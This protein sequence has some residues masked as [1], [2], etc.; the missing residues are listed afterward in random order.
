MDY[1]EYFREF[2]RLGL[3]LGL[4]EQ[5]IGFFWALLEKI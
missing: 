4:N 5:E 1:V 2:V 3:D